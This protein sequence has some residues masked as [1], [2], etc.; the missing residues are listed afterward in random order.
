MRTSMVALAVALLPVVPAQAAAVAPACSSVVSLAWS[1]AHLACYG[2]TRDRS[3]GRADGVVLYTSADQGHTWTLRPATGIPA[4]AAYPSPP[5][6]LPA[7]SLTTL[8]WWVSSGLYR[9]A[10]GGSTF[11]LVTPVVGGSGNDE[12]L[13]GVGTDAAYVNVKVSGSD[14]IELLARHDGEMVSTGLGTPEDDRRYMVVGAELLA[15]A[16]R[17]VSYSPTTGYTKTLVIYAC[18]ATLACT[19]ERGQLPQ[20][21]GTGVAFLQAAWA[22]GGDKASL[23]AVTHGGPSLEA[24]TTSVSTDGG[25]T[26]AP[27]LA[28]SMSGRSGDN[29]RLALANSADQKVILARLFD[30]SQ[31]ESFS[32]SRD[33]G[34]SWRRVKTRTHSGMSPEPGYHPTLATSMVF[35]GS[36]VVAIRRTASGSVSP[37]CSDD[38][39]RSWTFSC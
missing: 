32:L 18:D 24:I 1:H 3:T 39:A 25:R 23:F 14:G 5:F 36:R 29:P 38:F 17:T 10:D 22:T 11:E 12:R 33:G 13:P 35:V 31:S 30:G 6:T 16:W 4:P 26:F 20:P 2:V 28:L 9:S 8:Y 34:R 19:E 21:S 27:V 7:K 37:A 15:V